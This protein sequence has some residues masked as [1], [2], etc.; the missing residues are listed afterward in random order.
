MDAAQ[1]PAMQLVFSGTSPFA[2]GLAKFESPPYQSIVS[3]MTP[4][5]PSSSSGS[6]IPPRHRPNLVDF[7]QNSTEQD[8]WDLEGDVPSS[9]LPDEPPK[10]RSVP[11]NSTPDDADKP[12]EDQKAESTAPPRSVRATVQFNAPRKSDRP[13]ETDYLISRPKADGE[14]EDLSDWVEP[15]ARAASPAPVQEPAPQE[16]VA[17]PIEPLTQQDDEIRPVSPEP[18]KPISLRPQLHLSKVER[19]GLGVLLLLLLVGSI[20]MILS[21]FSRLPTESAHTEANDFPVSGKYVKISTAD[22]YWRPPVTEGKGREIVRRDTVLVPVVKLTASG[23]P[24]A[25][26]VVFLDGEGQMVG[27]VVTR[28]VQVD[29]PMEIAA[30]AGFEDIGMHAAYRTGQGKP[31]VVQIF[32][33]AT[34]NSPSQDFKRLIEMKIS[35]SRR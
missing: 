13:H 21:V 31:W 27:D 4:S 22:S 3:S 7:N 2:F 32:E 15:L 23:G 16:T 34:P 10:S 19:I 18:A 14:F 25:V 33:A 9:L 24:A 20:A 12:Q 1:C 8:L 17:Q 30:T 28:A 6:G 35:Y 11:T 29:V 5:T 26:R